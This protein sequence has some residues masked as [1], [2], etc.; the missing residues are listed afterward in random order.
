[1]LE[2][3]DWK[4]TLPLFGRTLVAKR[5]SRMGER[6]M[7]RG[8][9]SNS[10]RKISIPTGRR[11]VTQASTKGRTQGPSP[12]AEVGGTREPEQQRPLLP[13]GC[14]PQAAR[15]PGHSQHLIPPISHT[16]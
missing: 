5:M 2:P 11:E 15:D 8:G 3:P 10:S 9:E 14:D 6:V 16:V 1:M 4:E 12:T 13:G 7:L